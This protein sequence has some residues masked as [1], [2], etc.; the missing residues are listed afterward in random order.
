VIFTPL[1]RIL[2]DKKNTRLLFF[3]ALQ[4]ITISSK[5]VRYTLRGFLVSKEERWNIEIL[6]V[7]YRKLNAV[8]EQ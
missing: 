4:H 6:L 1:K 3:D 5:S 8:K 7:D 2:A